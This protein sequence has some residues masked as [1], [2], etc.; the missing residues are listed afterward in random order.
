MAAMEIKYLQYREL[1][2]RHWQ[3]FVDQTNWVVTF[4]RIDAN[5]DDLYT[6]LGRRTSQGD[7]LTGLYFFVEVMHRQSYSALDAFAV[8]QAH[9]AWVLLRPAIEAVL[10]MGIWVEDPKAAKL[11]LKMKACKKDFQEY[12]K[13]YEG[14]ALESAAL[15]RSA[16]IRAVLKRVN[17]QFLHPN[18]NYV[19]RSLQFDASNW[20]FPQGSV[21]FSHDDP[22]VQR[23][24]VLAFFHLLLVMQESV[25]GLLSSCQKETIALSFAMG[26]FLE[27]FE[28][29]MRAT[30]ERSAIHQEILRE[31]GLYVPSPQRKSPLRGAGF[32]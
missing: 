6:S 11:W 19:S 27:K 2:A 3:A 26:A 31:L 9:I 23:V 14:D 29:Q 4:D 13:R 7:R 32:S 24:H 22:D 1:Q 18:S 12:R 8:R 28:P 20:E 16:E 17:D 5:F 25:A 10:Y 21:F 30:A 15:P